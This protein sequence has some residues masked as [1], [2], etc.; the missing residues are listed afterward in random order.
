MTKKLNWINK[1][2]LKEIK[3]LNI[4]ESERI[5]T[6]RE[7]IKYTKGKI[8]YMCEIKVKNTVDHA[9]KILD[10]A[11]MLESTIFISFKHD[12]LLKIKKIYPNL[13]IGAIL[14]TG[15]SWFYNWLTKKQSILKVEQNGFY[16]INPYHRL[17][18]S[19]YIKLAHSKN[20]KVFPW[21]IN[22]IKKLNK[23]FTMGIDGVLTNHI[24]KAIKI[25]ESN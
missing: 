24:K 19:K 18:N 16:A 8:K 22:S 3:S 14:P 1:M 21:T 12:E 20:L 17:L 10:V 4:G 11:G 5:P 7:L 25:R 9:V 13:K 2:T 15:F 6:L 23:V